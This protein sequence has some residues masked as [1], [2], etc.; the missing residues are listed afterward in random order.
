VPKTWRV[1]GGVGSGGGDDFC[2]TLGSLVAN[3]KLRVF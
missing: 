1:G 2:D 3:M